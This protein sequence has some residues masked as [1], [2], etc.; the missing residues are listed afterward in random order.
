MERLRLEAQRQ[1]LE[2]LDL[3]Q[4]DRIVGRLSGSKAKG[5][6]ALSPLDIQRLPRAGRE[7]MVAVLNAAER[8]G[9]W[10]LQ[11]LLTV[12]CTIP[13]PSG[14]DRVIGLLPTTAGIWSRARSSLTDRWSDSLGEY[15]DTAVKKSSALRAAIA[16]AVMDESSVAL[17]FLSASILLDIEKFYDNVSLRLLMEAS[18]AQGFPPAVT[19][20]EVQLFLAP[21]VLKSRT[22]CSELV[23]P[24][25]SI[26]AGSAHGVKL[27]KVFLGPILESVHERANS[28]CAP[29]SVSGR[30]WTTRSSVARARSRLSDSSCEPLGPSSWPRLGARGCRFRTRRS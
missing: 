13:K 2:P 18:M 11:L 4:V 22:S 1:P 21:R 28:P 5:A 29:P 14:G 15:W 10:P 6:D 8:H 24:E 17:G 9:C 26:V 30:S 16:R 27:A 7:Q 19:L 3:E 12:C 20:L 25:R 23:V